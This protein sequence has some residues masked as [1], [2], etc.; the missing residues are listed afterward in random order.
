MMKSFNLPDIMSALPFPRSY[1]VEHGRF[2]AGFLPGDAEPAQARVKLAALADCGVTSVINLMEEDEKDH[3]VQPFVDYRPALQEVAAQRG[4][5]IEWMRRAIPDLGVPAVSE[6]AET[7]DLLDA[8]RHDGCVYVHC[9]GGRGRTG[10]VV[11]CWLARHGIAAGDGVLQR[12]AELTAHN[13][14][15]FRTIPET[16]AQRDFVRQWKEGQ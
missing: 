1:R 10:T 6:M 13:R 8:A 12:L 2:L 16:P 7:L 5:K 15:S 4:V 14:P 11:G 3:S 9:W